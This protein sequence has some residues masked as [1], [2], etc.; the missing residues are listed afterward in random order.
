MARVTFEQTS[1]DFKSGKSLL[2]QLEQQGHCIPNRCR[3]GNCHSC[4]LEVQSGCV[5]EECQSGLSSAQ[6]L[7]KRFLACRCFNVMQD[8]VVRMP[9][10]VLHRGEVMEKYRQSDGQ[11]FVKLVTDVDDWQGEAYISLV[12]NEQVYDVTICNAPMMGIIDLKIPQDLESLQRWLT[13]HC[14]IGRALDFT[15]PHL[16]PG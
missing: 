10:G 13:D 2:Q 6:I 11:I 4:L 5:S 3:K 1:F 12:V 8:L 9:S 7:A 16:R 15:G 14:R